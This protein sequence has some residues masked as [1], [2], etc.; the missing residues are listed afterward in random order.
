MAQNISSAAKALALVG[1]IAAIFIFAPRGV[2]DSQPLASPVRLFAALMIALQFVIY[3]YD[4]WYAVIY[5]GEE[6]TDPA[7]TFRA[8]CSGACSR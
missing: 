2:H 8:P 6:V 7:A 3:T 1:L 4:G 5:F